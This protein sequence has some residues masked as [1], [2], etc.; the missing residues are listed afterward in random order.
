MGQGMLSQTLNILP[1]FKTENPALQDSLSFLE[2]IVG[3]HFKILH[4]DDG[5]IAI[6]ISMAIELPSIANYENIDIRAQEPIL[7]VFDINDYPTKAPLVFTDRLDFPKNKLAHL[8]IAVEGR[9]PGFCYVRGDKDLWYANKTIKDLLVRIQ[10]WL[11]D[12][13]TG[14]LTEDGNQYEPLR[15]EGYSGVVIYDY[16][17]IA[18][19][20]KKNQRVV[21]DLNFA[22]GLFERIR[23]EDVISF[24]FLKLVTPGTIQDVMTEFE[25]EKK[26]DDQNA[27]KRNLHFGYVLWSDNQESHL[28]Y[29]IVLPKKWSEFTSFC[30]AFGIDCQRFE[31][32]VC[33]Y[34]GNY[35]LHFPVIVAIRRPKQLIGYSSE[36]EFVNFRFRVEIA[37]VTNGK[38]STDFE[39]RFQAHNQPLTTKLATRISN[40]KQSAGLKLIFGCGALGSK[41]GLHFGRSGNHKLL[42]SDPDILSSHNM[43]RHAL[44]ANKIAVNKANALAEEIKSMFPAEQIAVGV[45][46][47]SINFSNAEIFKPVTR[48]FDFTASPSFFNK[49]VSA[50]TI[51]HVGISSSSI[52]DFGNLGLTLI[53]GVNRNPRIDDLQVSLYALHDVNIKIQRWLQREQGTAEK[54][55][56]TVSIGVGC[57]SETT[58]LSDVKVSSHAAFAAGVLE[59]EMHDRKKHGSIFLNRIIENPVYSIETEHYEVLPFDVFPAVNNQIWSVRFR[60]GIV[61]QMHKAMVK[62]KRKET[63]GVFV[64]VAN[65]KTKTIHITNLIPAPPDSKANSVCFY[66]GVKGLPNTIETISRSSGGQLGYIGEWHSHPQG[67]DGLSSVDLA[68]VARFKSEFESLTT[69]LPVFLTVVTPTAFLPFVF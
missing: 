23:D 6:P 56:V 36:F 69:P 66:R 4:W 25:E 45:G 67:P 60:H 40:L 38:F 47:S 39:V 5:H 2:S 61:V 32:F 52:S 50:S 1:D 44:L 33:S 65:Y 13:A 15:L 43:V 12:A 17:F 48:V 42:L 8:Y 58:I 51:D 35:F 63:G 14:Q 62:S 54:E 27:T 37:D 53:E 64:G 21:E 57:N 59:R 55:N 16:D 9:T 19:V 28:D 34:D 31:N 46:R 11:R 68:S 29:N 20:V 41:I 7:I 49:L 30:E 10:N 24:R 18:D 26:K 3:E 22:I